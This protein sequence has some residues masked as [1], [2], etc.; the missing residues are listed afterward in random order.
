MI[1]LTQQIVDGLLF[2]SSIHYSG[3]K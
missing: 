2:E 1:Q 3:A